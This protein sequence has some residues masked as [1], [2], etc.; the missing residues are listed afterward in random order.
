MTKNK[1]CKHECRDFLEKEDPSCCSKTQ[2][3]C[4]EEIGLDCYKT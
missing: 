4:V 3:I 2:N 1:Q